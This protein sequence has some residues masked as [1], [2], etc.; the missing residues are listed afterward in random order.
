[1]ADSLSQ[2]CAVQLT[3]SLREVT[4]SFDVVPHFVIVPATT[5]GQEL[6]SLLSTTFLLWG[7]RKGKVVP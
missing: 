3:L 1:M 2:P 7:G 4:L 6:I 5:A